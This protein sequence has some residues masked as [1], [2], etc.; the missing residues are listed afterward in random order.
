MGRYKNASS[1]DSLPQELPLIYRGQQPRSA[2]GQIVNSVPFR[3][4]GLCGDST[5]VPLQPENNHRQQVNE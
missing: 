1:V 2:K 3:P 5:T 4:E